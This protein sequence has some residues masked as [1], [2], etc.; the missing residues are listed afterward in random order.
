[1]EQMRVNE[2]TSEEAALKVFETSLHL[3]KSVESLRRF[4]ISTTS[5]EG[6]LSIQG[7]SNTTTITMRACF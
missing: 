1:M 5:G 6:K 4:R 2:R 3:A 7:I